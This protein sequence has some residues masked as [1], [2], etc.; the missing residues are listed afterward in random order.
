MPF[1]VKFDDI[2]EYKVDAIV[3]SLGVKGKVLGRLCANI[4]EKAKSPT[5]NDYIK[6]QVNPVGTILVTESGD[7]PCKNIIHVVTPFKKDDDA[8][9][10]KLVNAYKSILNKAILLG[11]KSIALPFIGT[12]ANGY[13]ENEAYEAVMAACSLILEQEEKENKDILEMT[14][15]A[16]LKP[17][18]IRNRNII[19]KNIT[20]FDD[21]KI[22]YDFDYC[23]KMINKPFERS[24]L[25]NDIVDFGAEMADMDEDEL[26]IPSVKKYHYPYDFVEDFIIQR[27]FKEKAFSLEGLDRRR[28]NQMKKQ[29]NLKKLDIYRLAFMCKMSKT[30]ILQFMVIAGHCF[31]PLDPTDVFFRNYINGEYGV[32]K[33]LYQLTEMA[34]DQCE[35][36]FTYSEK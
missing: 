31:S 29:K 9:N 30:E 2:T 18:P 7:L 14:V 19:F 6:K 3:N 20:T 5:L 4:L 27:D 34:Y 8:N 21:E 11:Y 13:T 16:Y 35:A 15:V 24:Q 1:N 12:G 32:A 26:L 36:I 22:S 33:N 25:C 10:K 17:Q 28:K 23:L